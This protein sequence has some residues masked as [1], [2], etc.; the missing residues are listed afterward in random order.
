MPSK[1]LKKNKASK[2][3]KPKKIKAP[4]KKAPPK[5]APPKKKAPFVPPISVSRPIML[6][7]NES[8][9]SGAL[10]KQLDVISSKE[11]QL[12]SK[13]SDFKIEF[14][15][16][17]KEIKAL[18]D[19]NAITM[20]SSEVDDLRTNYDNENYE[21]I[22][23]NINSMLGDK[24][25]SGNRDLL[26][27]VKYELKS[28][29][30]KHD[31]QMAE[32]SMPSDIL[33]KF[34]NIFVRKET[35]SLIDDKIA[36]NDLIDEVNIAKSKIKVS[37]INLLDDEIKYNSLLDEKEIEKVDVSDMYDFFGDEEIQEKMPL[38]FTKK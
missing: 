3:P 20:L 21:F 31:L 32:R 16:K 25:S 33:S 8:S 10:S 13:L 4:P 35:K 30:E 1:I 15:N 18:E 17:N 38:K 5:K 24:L 19:L 29:K 27:S 7:G 2:A 34:K 28:V 26:T 37:K 22:K 9:G 23:S 14:E 11:L 36:N 6:S 12:E